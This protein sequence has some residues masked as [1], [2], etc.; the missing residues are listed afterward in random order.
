MQLFSMPRSDGTPIVAPSEG[1]I[2]V[3]KPFVVAITHNELLDGFGMPLV[4]CS[5][6]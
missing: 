4:V 6:P 3:D 1:A 2:V 5:V